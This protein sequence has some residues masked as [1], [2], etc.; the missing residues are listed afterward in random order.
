MNDIF[1]PQKTG[2]CSSSGTNWALSIRWISILWI[3]IRKTNCTIHWMEIYSADE[4]CSVVTR[5]HLGNAI[6]WN[7]T[8][9]P[10]TAWL[11]FAKFAVN[12]DFH[13]T[14]FRSRGQ[15]LRKFIRTEESV[16][17]TKEKSLTPTGIVWNVA[18]FSLIWNT[19][20]AAAKSCENA[21]KGFYT[22]SVK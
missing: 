1:F 2:S 10:E 7:P 5:T 11:K 3:S 15:H 21:L 19:N 8:Y 6:G 12:R 20:M 4:S 9:K 18:A 14:V 17:F 22:V 16:L 13:K